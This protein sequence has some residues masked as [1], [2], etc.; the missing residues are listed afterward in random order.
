MHKWSR[1]LSNVKALPLYAHVRMSGL[2]WSFTAATKVVSGI[3]YCT[4]EKIRPP[5]WE[6]TE[7]LFEVTGGEPDPFSLPMV[8][9]KPPPCSPCVSLSLRLMR[10]RG[11]GVLVHHKCC[12]CNKWLQFVSKLEITHVTQSSGYQLLVGEKFADV[13]L[14]LVQVLDHLVKAVFR[15]M[16]NVHD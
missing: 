9:E 7:D 12:L 16:I 8:G 13:V 15:G 10:N 6:I 11:Q 14:N 1:P 5:P 2:V 3:Y 4:R